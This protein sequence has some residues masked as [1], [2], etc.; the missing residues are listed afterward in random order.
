MQIIFAT[1]L[2]VIATLVSGRPEQ[3]VAV[4]Q[5]TL[6]N[7]KLAVDIEGLSRNEER[8]ADG[9]VHG[10]YS[11][12]DGNGAVQDVHYTAG[13]DGF[14][15]S[16]SSLPVA[17]VDH[18]LPVEETPEVAQARAAHLAKLQEVSH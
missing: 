3:I 11:Y 17:P 2:A 1:T 15:A 4:T 18:N 16:G 6:G 7:Y 13:K 9:S 12:V 14:Q 5:D 10:K 8:T